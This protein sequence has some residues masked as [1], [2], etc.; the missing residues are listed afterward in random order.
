L[1]GQFTI[2]R[3]P[4]LTPGAEQIVALGMNFDGLLFEAPGGYSFVVKMQDEEVKRIGFTVTQIPQVQQMG[5]S[6]P[7]MGQAT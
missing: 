1:T 2:G 7:S 4:L 6:P 3:P 5:M